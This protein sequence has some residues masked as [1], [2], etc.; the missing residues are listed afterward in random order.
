MI[1]LLLLFSLKN[2]LINI[3]LNILYYFYCIVYFLNELIL[4]IL[5]ELIKSLILYFVWYADLLGFVFLYIG[6]IL[7]Y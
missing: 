5:N 6:L 4:V 7:W 2:M 1:L 3:N